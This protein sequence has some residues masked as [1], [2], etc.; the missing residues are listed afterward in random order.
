MP[1]SQD[2]RW[3]RAT[4]LVFLFLIPFFTQAQIGQW[5]SAY[6]GGWQS[7]HLPPDQIDYAAF[8][9]I[10]HFSIY[11]IGGP[12]FDGTANGLTPGH[13]SAT[14]QA[15]HSSGK[16][17]II[18][19]GGWGADF[20]D[21]VSPANRTQSIANLVGYMQTYGYDG[22]DIDWEPVGDPPNFSIWIRDL[23]AAMN[24]FNPQSILAIAAFS[25]DQAVVDNQQYFDQI[26]LMTYDF[27]G[28]Y[29]GWVSWHNSPVYDGGYRFP[30]TGGL[31]PSANG[32]IDAYLASGVPRTK[33]GIGIDFLG[34]YWTGGDGTPTG[35]VT[36][37][38]QTYTVTPSVRSNVQYYEIMNTY[39]GLP[40]IWDSSAQAAYI[41]IDNPGS[42]SDRF[43]S[44]DNERTM[45]A[46][47]AYVWQKGIGGVIV[48]ELGAGYRPSEPQGQKDF[49]LQAVKRAFVLGE[50]YVPDVTPPV[51]TLTS[52]VQGSQA[53]GTI[54]LSANASDNSGT[55]SVQFTLDGANYRNALRGAPFS[56][57]LNTWKFPNGIHQITA[58]ARDRSGNVDSSS[59]VVTINNVGPPPTV[60]PLIVFDES[61]LPPF[62]NGSW[63]SVVDLY[64]SAV[65]RSGSRSIKVNYLDWGALD[66][67]SGNWQS[68]VMIDP[69]VYDTLQFD[70][71]P[72]ESFDLTVSFYNGTEIP[73]NVNV[74]AD[75]W[76]HVVVPLNFFDQF[77]RFYLQRNLAGASSVYFDN[78]M[79]TGFGGAP[80]SPPRDPD[81]IKPTVYLNVPASNST[82]SGITTVGASASDNVGVV[83]V[84]FKIDGIN[85]GSEKEV[86]P[87]TALLNTW[88]HQNGSH[89]LTAVARDGHDNVDSV[90]IS[91]DVDNQ[92]PMPNFDL[93]V[94]DDALRSQFQNAS[95]G[96]TMI[97]RNTENVHSG[98]YSARVD[99]T[100]WGALDILS[101][102]WGSLIPVSPNEYDSLQFYIYPTTPFDLEVS[103]YGPHLEVIPL[104]ENR[105]NRVSV[106]IPADTSF[107]RFF[108][109]RNEQ[110]TATAFFDDIRFISKTPDRGDGGTTPGKTQLPRDYALNQNFPNPFNPRTTIR[111]QIPTDGFVTL[112]VYNTLGMEIESL[113][114]E[115]MPE[116]YHSYAWEAAGR[117]SGVYYYRLQV[118]DFVETRKM[119]LLK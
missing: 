18:S 9:H 5:V 66:F 67:V 101:G 69:T 4:C 17:A 6:Y 110:G 36:G 80:P 45:Y 98:M 90:T 59:A 84:Q 63:G 43:I 115:R 78:I 106:P 82:I 40:Q 1:A 76:N 118:N 44:F 10:L 12:N 117:S 51:V 50:Q 74:I 95:W 57:T 65:V 47:A 25:Y 42:A 20:T 19:V 87:Y 48:F 94:Y 70:V 49:L 96:A 54:A 113:V 119:M 92:G 34:Y 22:I 77:S 37:P 104:Y 83:G 100:G 93:V 29:P 105:W 56:T 86:P 39:D 23:R 3:K 81:S 109:R 27:S 28:P 41:S 112:K 88:Y 53:S 68:P 24:A 91:V 79:F 97:P 2:R 26:N 31:V 103:F 52:P 61:L 114:S 35:G 16:K 32:S 75:S 55:V 89:Q 62:I 21:A 64:N 116:G 46:K 73:Q 33:L 58:I 38:R 99:F 60:T 8:T 14:V 107:T 7:S 85:L 108:F 72:V 30:S 15:A 102:S 11:P 71:Y 13:M 111:Y